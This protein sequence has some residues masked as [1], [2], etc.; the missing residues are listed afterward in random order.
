MLAPLY[1]S[2][3]ISDSE[4][5]VCYGIPE[6]D[7][8]AQN[9]TVRGLCPLF[10]DMHCTAHGDVCQVTIGE[11]EINA[12]VLVAALVAPSAS[13]DLSATYWLIAGIAGVS[14]KVATISSVTIARYAVQVALQYEF[15]VRELPTDFSTGYLP[16]GST[17][18][19]QY[20]QSLYGTEVFEVNQNLQNIAARIAKRGGPERHDRGG[21]S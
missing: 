6:F 18:P 2:F 3:S 12:A 1:C 19:A 15:D 5:E 16:L 8:L 7:L 20:P 17:S 13:F 11:G 9:I 14:P 21:R 10:P 4:A